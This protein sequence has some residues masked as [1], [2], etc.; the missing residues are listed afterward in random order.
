M[1]EESLSAK[2]DRRP[3]QVL[4]NVVIPINSR[5]SIASSLSSVLDQSSEYDTPGTSVALTPAESFVK[6]QRSLKGPNRMS[7]NKPSYQPKNSFVGKRKRLE[8]DELMEAD[9]L[10]AQELQEREYGEDQHPIASTPQRARNGL[11]NDSE[12]SLLSDSYQEHS[13]D[14]DDFPKLDLLEPGRA[15]RRH[16][17][18]LLPQTATADAERGRSQEAS[19]DEDENLGV[20]MPKN[21]RIKTGYPTSLPPRAARDSAKKSL[22][23]RTTLGILDSEDSDLSDLSDDISLFDS[24][25]ISEASEDSEDADAGP[26]VV[27]ASNSLATA[28]AARSVSSAP[29]AI[30]TTGRRGARSTQVGNPTRGRRS[31]QRRVED[32]VSSEIPVIP[33]PRLT[34]TIGRKRAEKARESAPRDQ[35]HMD[36]S[37]RYSSNKAYP[38]CTT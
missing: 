2:R 37:S 32:R 3:Q 34:H 6:G 1:N 15:N 5:S 21:K 14:L 17:K 12:E 18:T 7:S 36:R 23:D 25:I 13:L 28:V 35:D 20:I 4:K 8:V 10:L 9:A 29:S 31:W 27:G 24:D 33:H 30:P 19:S 16:L 22:K 26:G 38:S 11:I